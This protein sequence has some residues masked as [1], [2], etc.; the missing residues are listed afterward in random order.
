MT[1]EFVKNTNRGASRLT[2]LLLV[3]LMTVSF[4]A[5]GGEGETESDLPVVEM[6]ESP[7]K[8]LDTMAAIGTG[9]VDSDYALLC[10]LDG[11]S[12]VAGLR[13][14]ERMYPA[15]L[16]KLMT[17]IVAYENA[18]D[19]TVLIEI[20]KEL[21]NQ[22]AEGSRVGI[23]VGDLLTVEQ[24]L[25]ALLLES[26]TDAALGLALHVAGSEQ[27]FVALMNQKAQEMGLKNTHF[28]N[29]TGLHDKDH[30]STAAEMAAVLAYAVNIPLGRTILTTERYVTYLKYYKNGE[31]T[32]YRMTFR[33][34]TLVS[35]FADNQV[36]VTLPDG[37]AVL[38][39]KTGFTDE[40]DYC[41]ATLAHTADGRE[42][43]LITGH[44]SSGENS[45][46][47]AVKLYGA[48]AGE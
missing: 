31:L 10:E 43:I 40:A 25:Y 38:G 33:N 2:A 15:S 13:A 11:L 21:K 1:R 34:T 30:Y 44:A 3:C 48:Y 4:V 6:D 16:T 7:V 39:G 45:A 32:D 9:A 26:D 24:M 46:K 28:A 8:G 42:Y 23:D 37:T 47:D 22:Y 17:F 36:S 20:T 19:H 27:A 35:R 18:A 12:A 41:L 14:T 29:V 5:C